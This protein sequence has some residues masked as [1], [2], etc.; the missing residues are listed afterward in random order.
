MTVTTAGMPHLS[1]RTI[2]VGALSVSLV[3]LAGSA[4][5]ATPDE[6][7][8]TISGI[9]NGTPVTPGRVTLDIPALADSG[10]GVPLTV[11]VASPM[12]PADH[13]REIHLLSQENPSTRIATFHLGPRAGRAT[14]STSIRFAASQ[15]ITAIARMA[16]GSLWSGTA[17][18]VVTEAACSEGTF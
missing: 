7:R 8:T 12:T 15:D 16:D 9:A 14:V 5:T 10:N 3:P 1:R 4:A 11:T 2:V 13:V 6:L 18:V 17:N